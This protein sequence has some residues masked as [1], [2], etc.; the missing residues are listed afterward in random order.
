MVNLEMFV[1]VTDRAWVLGASQLWRDARN[2][3]NSHG[4]KYVCEALMAMAI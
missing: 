4:K 1:K 3:W 2:M